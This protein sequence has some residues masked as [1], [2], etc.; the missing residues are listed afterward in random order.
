L[1]GLFPKRFYWLELAGN[2]H[3][4]LGEDLCDAAFEEVRLYL[5]Q[6]LK[7]ASPIP[8][9]TFPNLA[10]LTATPPKEK[11]SCPGTKSHGCHA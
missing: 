9:K 6:Q 5:G 1:A 2:A 7:G 10:K 4:S 3:S 8:G 11:V